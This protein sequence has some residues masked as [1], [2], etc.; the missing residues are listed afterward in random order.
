MGLTMARAGAQ[1]ARRR[2][3]PKDQVLIVNPMTRVIV[4][5]FPQS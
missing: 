4:N 1:E 2:S 3:R 5:M